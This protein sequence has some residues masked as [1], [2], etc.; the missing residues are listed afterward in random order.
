MITEFH[1]LRRN[2]LIISCI[3]IIIH[4]TGTK[5][6]DLFPILSQIKI[7]KLAFI[8][9]DSYSDLLFCIFLY[10]F[11]RFFSYLIEYE[12]NNLNQLQEGSYFYY[13]KTGKF[14]NVYSTLI[15]KF[16]SK[17]VYDI[18]IP[19]YLSSI[20]M[21]GYFLNALSG[22][23]DEKI[24]IILGAFFLTFFFL[25]IIFLELKNI[26]FQTKKVK[27]YKKDFNYIGKNTKIDY[28][29]NLYNNKKEK[30]FNKRFK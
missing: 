26:F 21:M 28:Y 22:F 18:L 8:L 15:E 5:I 11:F 16:L 19:L 10:F 29:R 4:L 30:L 27:E 3:L 9:I 12:K 23:N 14:F 2:L 25:F 1:K 6:T 7:E 24:G 17:T 13:S 20:V